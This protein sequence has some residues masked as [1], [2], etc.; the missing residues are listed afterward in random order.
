MTDQHRGL[1]EAAANEIRMLRAAVQALG[2]KA[3]AYDAITQILGMMPSNRSGG[4][5]PD[6]AWQI[7]R[8]LIDTKDAEDGV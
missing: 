1:L 8:Y 6:L 5:V 3:E 2:T 4:G 7:D